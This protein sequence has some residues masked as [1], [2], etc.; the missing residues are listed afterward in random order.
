MFVG[1]AHAWKLVRGN[2]I[3]YYTIAAIALALLLAT[4]L[5]ALTPSG[6]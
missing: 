4:I 6:E 1:I 3:L 5:G 2:V